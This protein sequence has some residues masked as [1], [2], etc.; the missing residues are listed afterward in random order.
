MR[1]TFEKKKNKNKVIPMCIFK[2]INRR[3]ER[4]FWTKSTARKVF[5]DMKRKKKP[6]PLQKPTHFSLYSESKK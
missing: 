5:T 4:D 3:D 6:T 2:S 1:Q